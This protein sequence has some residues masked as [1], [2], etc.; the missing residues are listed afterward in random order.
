MGPQQS[1]GHY[2]ITTKLGNGGMGEVWRAVDTKLGRDVAVKVLP[3]S[4]AQDAERMARFDREAKALAS[5]NHP[6]IAQIYGVEDRAMVMELVEGE[7]LRGPLPLETVIDYARQIADALEAAHEKGI[8]HRD[9]KPR[10]I[11]VTP[12][13][14]VKVLD[15]GLARVAEETASDKEDSPTITISPTR[16]GVIL[17]T[18]GYMSPEQARGMPVDNRADIWAFGCVLYEM[19]TGK[20]A[21][22]GE[23]TTDILAGVIGAEPDLTRVPAKLRRMLRRCLE[24]DPRKRLRDI[25]DVWELLDTAEA[26]AAA[27]SKRPWIAAAAA[28]LLAV[29]GW[30]VAW[31]ATRP[32]EYPLIRLSVDLGPDAVMGLNTTVAISPDGQRIVYPARGPDGKQ[33]LATQLL[34]EAQPAFLPGT[35]G[36]AD[37]FFSPDGQWICFFSG[38]QFNKIAVQGGA[39]VLSG[40]VTAPVLGASWGAGDDLIVAMGA[41]FPLYR[42]PP[43]G[44]APQ[45]FTKL[46]AGDFSHRWPQVL[47]G[48]RAVLFSASPSPDS[49]DN[50]YLE[51]ASLKDGTSKIVQRGAYYGRYLPGGYLAYVRQGTIFASKFDSGG[52][53]VTGAPVPMLQDVAANPGTGGGQ[54]D[55]SPGPS[56]HGIFVYMSGNSAAHAAKINWLDSTG[57]MQPL[58][59]APGQYATPRLSP[60]GR[61]LAFV[62]DG[63]IFVADSER[64]TITQVTFT[65]RAAIPVWAPDGKHIAFSLGGNAGGIGW[66]RSDGAGDAR[67]LLETSGTATPWSFAPGGRLA[68]FQRNAGTGLT[69][70]TAPLNLSDPDRPQPGKPESAWHAKGDDYLPRFSPDGRWI[71][72]RSNESGINEIYV[73]PFP[74]SRGGKLQISS[75]GGMYALWAGNGREL[76]YQTGDNRVMALDYKVEGDSFLPG[77]PHT[78]Y[79]QPLFY[80][81]T[82]NLDL[83]PDGKRFVVLALPATAPGEKGTVHVTMLLN[84]LDELKRRIP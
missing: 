68:F 18:A 39:P 11:M 9:L 1:I 3:D 16:A 2:R 82:S 55:F 5:L 81:G 58:I 7:T 83:A 44:G 40:S 46:D 37:A 42:I 71:A 10:N 19:L 61:R 32:A 25:G 51:V 20:P 21:F 45:R 6:N 41:A 33:Q 74:A 56:G 36:G 62:K 52:L 4:F 26:P 80:A 66:I 59:T 24:K 84:F 23:T 69:V 38:S 31:R 70:W 30:F 27:E 67:T 50:G 35:Q 63:D 28:T 65:G 78:W 22:P 73:R 15:F 29:A 48:G 57:G 76:F 12:A 54:F 53:R 64:N 49:W 47:P 34:D 75:G 77:K 13:G 8:V 43:D 17:G 72:Y 60:D 14:V 79:D